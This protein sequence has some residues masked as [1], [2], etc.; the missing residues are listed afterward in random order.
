[1]SVSPTLS[2][3]VNRLFTALLFLSIS[4]V[5]LAQTHTIDP[6]NI[7][8]CRDDFGIPTIIAPTDA[9]AAYGLAWVQA[10]DNFFDM[11]E[12]M[13]G[14]K[15]LLSSIKGKKGVLLDAASFII[16]V[17]TVVEQ[18][19]DTTF[20]PHFK[21]MISAYTQALNRYAELHPDEV[22]HKDLL[23]ITEKNIIAGYVL[24]MC[25]MSNVQYD[26]GRILEN[27]LDAILEGNP[28]PSGSNGIAISPERSEDG[29]TYLVSNSHQPL[30][31]FATWYEVQIHTDEGWHFHGGTFASGITPFVGTNEHLGWT[32]CLNYN[33]FYDTYKLRMHPSKKNHYYFDGKWLELEERKLKLKVKIAGIKIPVSRKFYRSIHGPVFKTKSGYFAMRFPGNMI[34]GSAE[35]WYK[36][37]RSTNFDEFKKALE[38][39]QS[40]S[41]HAVY[42]DKTGNI[43]F[44]D[45]G[46]YPYRNPNYN[47]Q[48][49]L[50]G[51]TSAT[52]W[53]KKFYP[54]DSLVQ[55]KNPPSGYVF[56]MNNSGFVCTGKNDNPNKAD[57]PKHMGYQTGLTARS[58]RFQF[59]M[60]E[61]KHRKVSYEELQIMKNDLKMDFPLF[62]RALQNMDM[63]RALDPDKH[64]EIKDAIAVINKWDGNTDADNEQAAIISVSIQYVL[65]YLRENH[66]SE[67]NN[68]LPEE[69]YYDAVKFA[70]KHLKKHFGKLEL[71]LGEVQRHVRGDVNLPIGGIPEVIA[72]MYTVPYKKGTYQSY[73]GETFILY[74]TYNEDGVERIESINCYGSSNH[75]DSPHYTDQME[76]F[77]NKELKSIS[78]SKENALSKAKKNYHPK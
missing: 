45:N 39:Q 23:P 42:A 20:S 59:L 36:M 61:R 78:L 75:E 17:N 26:L 46:L 30:R 56:N 66:I 71:P 16:D 2:F 19:Y 67:L 48:K 12:P 3:T 51:D 38:M 21:K 33:D 11:Q 27:K 22:R 62:T 40:A 43:Y 55:V 6:D 68:W 15:G 28:L 14:I 4:I 57:Y 52:L 58:I 32:H 24:N 37:N 70:K 47:W 10:E 63:I 1:M 29:K 34:I 9:E 5:S 64:P 72:Q 50:P 53:E 8:I 73:V 13:L 31:G 77:V 41:M 35:Q 60:K 65:K 76:M 69:V 49:I 7:T 25:L 54:L 44:I 74:V 18:H